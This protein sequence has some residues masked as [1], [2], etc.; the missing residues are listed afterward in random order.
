[1]TSI[2]QPYLPGLTAIGQRGWGKVLRQV[3]FDSVALDA[4][5]DLGAM[6]LLKIDIQGGETLVFQGAETVL[7]A[8]VV[9]IVE[10]RYLRLYE[11][12]PMLG[13]VDCELRR[14]GFYL[15]KFM[16]N[17]SKALPNSQSARL[18][19]KKVADQLVDGDGV[20]VRNIAEPERLSDEQLKHLAILA[21]SV[22]S[23]HSLV[24]SCLDRL[25]ERG[26]AAAD[27]PARY[28][29]TLPDNLRRN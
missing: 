29:D 18:N 14:Q 27:L 21:S 3:E 9:V 25:V 6:D 15:H 23:S 24:L 12:E 22:F 8:A 5:P 11:E 2:F 17:K 7:A 28:V 19:R 13:G 20:Y 1:M 4:I 16:F 10:L 26:V